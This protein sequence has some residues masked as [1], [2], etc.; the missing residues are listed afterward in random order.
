MSWRAECVV[1]LVGWRLT[2][3]RASSDLDG[4]TSLLSQ[5]KP[6]SLGEHA[7]RIVSAKCLDVLMAPFGNQNE[8]AQPHTAH[9]A[10]RLLGLASP[11]S[12]RATPKYRLHD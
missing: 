6:S 2:Y 1:A 3:G 5:F 4:P 7:P 11:L 9:L 10:A 12:F 8:Q